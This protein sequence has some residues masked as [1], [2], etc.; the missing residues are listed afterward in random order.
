M[1]RHVLHDTN[2]SNEIHVTVKKTCFHEALFSQDYH[3]EYIYYPSVRIIE[4]KDFILHM[5]KM[6]SRCCRGAVENDLVRVT[7]FVDGSAL[8]HKPGRG[9]EYLFPVKFCE[10]PFNLICSTNSIH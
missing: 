6:H 4:Y 9:L 8:E 7:I 1:G 3:S 10:N 5:S 2:S